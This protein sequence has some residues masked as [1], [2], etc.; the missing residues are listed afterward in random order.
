MTLAEVNDGRILSGADTEMKNRRRP[1][2]HLEA[3]AR[4]HHK[5][6]LLRLLKS[7][8]FSFTSDTE[9]VEIGC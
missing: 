8:K 9:F 4:F 1:L 7:L 3:Y 2:G 6:S 5:G